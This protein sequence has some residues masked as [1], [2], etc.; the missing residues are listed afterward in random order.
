MSGNTGSGSV[1]GGGTLTIQGGTAISTSVSSSTI[2][3]N[4]T[5]VTS[6]NGA[7]GAIT[8]S[9]ANVTNALGYTPANKA[10]DNFTGTV[11]VPSLVANTSVT[12]N[13]SGYITTTSY[14]T[15]TTSQNTIDSFATTT[16]RSAK[17]L[18]QMTSGTSYHMIE[19]NVLHDGATAWLTQ[20][21]EI[22]TGSSLGTFDASVS[23]GNLNL[24]FTPTNAATT[25]RLVRTNVTV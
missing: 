5:G 11:T 18:A 19:L 17:Y 6:F 8:F 20:Y 10:G 15:T 14:T 23:A 24:L 16:Y 22:F 21:G 9:S 1:A 7:T 13:A 3:I 12:V 2:T 25:I 4:N